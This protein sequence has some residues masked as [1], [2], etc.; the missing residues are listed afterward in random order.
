MGLIFPSKW[1]HVQDIVLIGLKGIINVFAC[2]SVGRLR[3]Q[4][5]S[6]YLVEF[7]TIFGLKDLKIIP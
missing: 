5:T 1:L 6:H 2:F 4:K 7:S 3:S